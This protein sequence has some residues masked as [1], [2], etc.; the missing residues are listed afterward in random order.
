MLISTCTGG[1]RC[2]TLEI[3]HI[4][5]LVVLIMKYDTYEHFQC[6]YGTVA[7]NRANVIINSL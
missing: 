6:V 3:S 4:A 7:V 5:M 1:R 2:I